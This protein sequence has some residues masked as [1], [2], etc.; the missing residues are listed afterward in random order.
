MDA[1]PRAELQSRS[2]E[3]EAPNTMM[4]ADV[5]TSDGSSTQYTQAGPKPPPSGNFNEQPAKSPSDQAY[6]DADPHS[7]AK[8]YNADHPQ[9]V[10]QFNAATGGSCMVGGELDV[11]SVLAFQHQHGV[12]ADGMVGPHTVAA[13]ATKK[14]VGT[15]SPEDQAEVMQMFQEVNGPPATGDLSP[16]DRDGLEAH[17]NTVGTPSPEGRAEAMRMFQEVNGPPTTG[18]L[19]PEDAAGLDQ[20]QASSGVGTPS[21]EGRAEAMKLFEEVNGGPDQP[22][23]TTESGAPIKKKS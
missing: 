11:A 20:R 22:S 21:P 15:V 13:A 19:S 14:T 8:K 1:M 10:A 7:A 2:A 4:Q 12:T 23:P 17:P 5:D 16:E 3:T 6:D 18:E 9:Y